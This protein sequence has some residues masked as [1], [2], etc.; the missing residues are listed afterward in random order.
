VSVVANSTSRW[1][2]SVPDVL[3]R[4]ARVASCSMAPPPRARTR[5]SPAARRAMVALLALAEGSL[6]VAGEE[7]GDG[8]ASFGLD[9][10]VHIDEAP[11]EAGGDKRADGGFARAHE[12]GED[13]A[14]GRD[15]SRCFPS[16][17]FSG[18]SGQRPSAGLSEGCW[19]PILRQKEG[20]E[21]V[22]GARMLKCI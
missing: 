13:D 19:C 8:Y 9:Y 2:S 3:S 10:V 6:A 1:T 7:L 15:L 12:A 4:S 21:W 16:L 14:A 11:T 17:Y 20:E 22:P 5:E 18:S